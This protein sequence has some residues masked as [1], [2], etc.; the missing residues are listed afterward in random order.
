MRDTP[1]EINDLQIVVHNDDETP[2]EFVVDLLRSVF[3]RSEAEARAAE[4]TISKQGKGRMRDFSPA[5]CPRDAGYRAK[6]HQ[7]G[8]TPS[9]R[10]HC[11]CGR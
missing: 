9:P 3:A 2:F 6:A 11:A 4:A 7:S 10:D 5:H 1:D 8:W